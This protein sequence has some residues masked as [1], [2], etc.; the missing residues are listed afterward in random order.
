M[1]R[2]NN[3]KVIQKIAKAS[4]LANKRKNAMM[5]A[6]ICLS[7]FMI[8]CIFTV[9]GT[10]FQMKN[11]QDVRLQ[12]GEF[13]AWLYGGFTKEQ[14]AQCEKNEDI[15]AVGTEAFCA[16][17]EKTEYDDTLHTNFVWADETKWNEIQKPART[18]MKG[19]Y[20]EK[21]NEVLVT[22]DALKDCGFKNLGVGDS[23]WITY[24]DAKGSHTKKF[25]IS[26]LWDGYGE[27]TI[28]YVSKSFFEHSGFQL[29]DY[30]R[31]FLYIKFK[32]PI[33]TEKRQKQLEQSL[34]LGEKQR[35]IFTKDTSRSVE[36]ASG[37]IGLA[38]VVCLS[39]YLL[40]YNI[41]Y[42]SISGNIRYYGLMQTIGMTEKQIY[43][44]IQRQMFL[45]G[46]VGIIG[47]MILGTATS[48]FLIPEIVKTLGIW[49]SDIQVAFHPF[50]FILSIFVTGIT[51]Y[52]SSWKPAKMA[53]QISPVEAMGYRGISGR[54]KSHKTGKGNILWKMAREQL[55]KDKKKAI[56][57]ILSLGASLSVFLSLTTLIESQGA[58]TI[59]SNYMDADMVIYNDT[60]KKEDVK[61]WKQLF[62]DEF[63]KVVKKEKGIQE[64]HVEFSQKIVVPWEPDFAEFWMSKM[65]DTWMNVPYKKED[66]QKNPQNYFSFLTGI[67]E[68]EFQYL[69]STLESPV[70]EKEFKEGK[71]GILY[72]NGLK[73]KDSDV[74]NKKVSFCLDEN[75]KI[76]YDLSVGSVTDDSYYSNM[77]IGPTLVVSDKFLKKIVSE[78][79]VSKVH[80]QYKKE[81]DEKTESVLKDAIKQSPDSKD[82]SYGSKIDEVKTVKKAQGNMMEIGIGIAVLLAFIGILNY[83]NTVSGNIQ[84]RQ[85]EIAILESIGMTEKQVKKML[86]LE[87]LLFAGSSVLF[88]G[89]IG[90]GITYV[91]YQSMNYREI[92]FEFPIF[93][94]MVMILIIIFI[95]VAIPQISYRLICG[96]KSIVER[97]QCVD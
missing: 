58:R 66:Y 74:K 6:A 26:G 78:P 33:V 25:I 49:Q 92:P 67:D 2:N 11:V 85:E 77:G 23:F 41:L 86:V 40:I 72:R 62:N 87:G 68:K 44:L 42:L 61:D 59:V 88:T 35:L 3:R 55:T 71:I 69:N 51:V 30:G 47:G 38:L 12:G 21:E 73:I 97:I 31:G 43:H 48:F 54:R 63:L 1:L 14:K 8:F 45:I 52:L 60:V 36:I 57:V 9:G 84:S 65:Y 17:G 32:S 79:W 37:T 91:L 10:W 16:Y 4:L 53:M 27:K 34:H 75:R 7:A 70:N 39:A 19:H 96:K 50:I 18:E 94:I 81:Y 28:F 93:P 95:C 82:F 80:I 29:S 24:A 22:K 15:K 76:S 13:G 90:M 56:V 46:G 83:I 5:A 89:T 64:T 20:P